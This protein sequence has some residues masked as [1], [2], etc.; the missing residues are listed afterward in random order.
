[1]S[2][3][4]VRWT[5]LMATLVAGWRR[6]GSARK[7]SESGSAFNLKNVFSLD[8]FSTVLQVLLTYCLQASEE[9]E[10]REQ[11]ALFAAASDS[12]DGNINGESYIDL[13]LRNVLSVEMLLKRERD[14]QELKIKELLSRLG[15]PLRKTASVPTSIGHVGV[16]DWLFAW[17]VVPSESIYFTT[18]CLEIVKV[19]HDSWVGGL[20]TRITKLFTTVGCLD[21]S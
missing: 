7:W 19:D 21:F 4:R 2:S 10:N 3:A 12:V 5:V 16:S 1:M 9:S 6:P 15:K 13:Y 14:R 20:Q 17:N 8:R 18:K 11:L